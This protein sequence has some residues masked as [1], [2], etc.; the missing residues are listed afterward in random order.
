MS[1]RIVSE[2]GVRVRYGAWLQVPG[3]RPQDHHLVHLSEEDY[4]LVLQDEFAKDRDLGAALDRVKQRL[5][6]MV[7][8]RI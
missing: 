8:R 1:T 2:P 5:V 7:S 3:R 4:R 6:K